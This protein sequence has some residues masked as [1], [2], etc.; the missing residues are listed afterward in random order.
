MLRLKV[1]NRGAHGEC[2]VLGVALGVVPLVGGAT[3]ERSLAH[4][5]G[6]EGDVEIGTGPERGHDVEVD[7]L[8]ERTAVVVGELKSLHP[9]S[10]KIYAP[11]TATP[12][13]RQR[14]LNEQ[15]RQAFFDGVA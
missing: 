4:R 8:R 2:E 11:T 12:F 13:E 15:K 7:V 14:S 3:R 1:A 9:H 6:H 10:L 5:P